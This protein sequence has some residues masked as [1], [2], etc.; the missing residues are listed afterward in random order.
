LSPKDGSNRVLPFLDMALRANYGDV[1]LSLPRCFRGP[2]TIRTGDDR[3]AFSPAFAKRAGLM[4]DVA[5]VR[6]YFVGDRPRGGKWG[7]STSNGGEAVGEDLLLDEISVDGKFTS[8][9]INWDGGDEEVPFMMPDP[10]KA[11]C[12]GTERFFTSGRVC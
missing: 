3:I 9:R 1:Y 5:G 10:W 4:S 11:F 8:V 7:S 2:I 12:G 6:V